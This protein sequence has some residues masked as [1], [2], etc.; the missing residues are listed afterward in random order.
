M[1]GPEKISILTKKASQ[2]EKTFEIVLSM[3]W[4]WLEKHLNAA[5]RD[6]KRVDIEL[7]SFQ[8]SFKSFRWGEVKKN[9]I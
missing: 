3:A 8:T 2:V 5:G 1:L 9:L 6:C 7:N 4:D